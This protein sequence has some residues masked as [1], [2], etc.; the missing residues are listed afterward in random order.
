MLCSDHQAALLLI[1]ESW[2]LCNHK[3]CATG[4]ALVSLPSLENLSK[5]FQGV[6]WGDIFVVD[7]KAH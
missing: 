7:K 2:K 5:Q 3:S 6:F 1:C 4:K